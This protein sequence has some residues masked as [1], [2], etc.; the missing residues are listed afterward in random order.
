[1][2]NYL[3]HQI[4]FFAHLCADRY[5]DAVIVLSA[6]L[7][8]R[9]LDH[10][11][12]HDG[13]PDELRASFCKLYVNLYVDRELY[14]SVKITNMPAWTILVAD[15]AALKP[16]RNDKIISFIKNYVEGLAKGGI[17]V[18]YHFSFYQS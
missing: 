9:L 3:Q 10:F 7:N 17:A 1:M 16:A 11:L 2:L 14:E 6:K 13:L 5:E 4:D 8:I 12:L 15:N 18:S